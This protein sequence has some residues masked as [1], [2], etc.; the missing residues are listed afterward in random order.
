MR[1]AVTSPSFSMN[2]LLR[3]ELLKVFP[4]AILNESG[5]KLEGMA[6]TDF[7]KD[8]DGIVVGLEKIDKT[9]INKCGKLKIISKY[10]VGLDS[11]D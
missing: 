7:I 11:I 8:A 3:K 9:V 10:G 6:L 1:I 4:D 5:T 2:E